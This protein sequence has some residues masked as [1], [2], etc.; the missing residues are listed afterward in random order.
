MIDMHSHIIPGVDDGSASVE[1]TFKM[2]DEA[3]K[4]GFTDIIMTSHF[5]THYYEPTPG[6]IIVW[7]NKLQE[8]LDSK[9]M[10]VKLHSGMEIYISN[11]MKELFGEKKIL[12]LCDSRYL[13]MELPLSSTINYLDHVLYFLQSLSI[14]VILAHPER[15]KSV[16]EN[17][18]L[19][20]EYIDKGALIQCNYG[21]ILGLYGNH[22]KNTVKTLLKKGQVHFLGSDCHKPNS[23]YTYIPQAEKKIKKIIGEREFFKISTLNPQKVIDNIEIDLEE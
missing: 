7:K 9:G 4:V 15:Y 2:I 3:K 5:L 20:Q 8:V 12:T 16:Q 21:S 11:R 23:V 1:E 13:L 10:D 17:P 14:Q 19:V 6:E 18:D 22:A